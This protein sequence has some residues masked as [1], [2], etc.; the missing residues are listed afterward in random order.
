MFEAYKKSL[1]FFFKNKSILIFSIL[2]SLLNSPLKW[3]L[4]TGLGARV[5]SIFI[6]AGF[7]GT[8]K[9]LSLGKK[10]TI[11]SFFSYAAY[12]FSYVILNLFEMAIIF[13]SNSVV[14]LFFAA[15]P[16]AM[17]GA[18]PNKDYAKVMFS[19][20]IFMIVLYRL[21]LFVNSFINTLINEK[22]TGKYAIAKIKKITWENPKIYF[23]YLIQ[24]IIY[25]ILFSISL[26]YG[27]GSKEEIDLILF[28]LLD[29]INAFLFL[30]FMI[31]N[32]YIYKKIVENN[33]EYSKKYDKYT[34]DGRYQGIVGRFI[35]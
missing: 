24:F 2:I 12:N 32:Y 33:E 8:V 15:L 5:L 25:I 18:T 29:I 13:V 11:K 21:P 30:Y 1:E 14:V 22:E 9:Y 27:M 16:I 6:V 23:N 31:T 7:L 10:F 35:L 4:L 34:Y 3:N 19:I 28:T 17:S 26:K 20:T